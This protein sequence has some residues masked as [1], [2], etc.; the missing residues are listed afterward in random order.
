MFSAL[1][2]EALL[3]R[4]RLAPF[5]I[6]GS[7]LLMVVG[8]GFGVP[9]IVYAALDPVTQ[10]AD[11]AQL[12]GSL[13]PSA[14]HHAAAGSYPLFGGAIMLIL[15][16]LIT[17]SEYRWKTWHARLSQGP[18]RTAVVLAKATAGACAVIVIAAAALA[19][20]MLASVVI[21]SIEGKSL[22]LPGLSALAAALGATALISVAW[23]SVGLALGVIFRGVGTALAVGL[24]WTLG[25]ENAV[26]G[27]AGILPVLEPVRTILLGPASGSLVA[28]L[29]VPSLSEGGTPGVAAYVSGP[30]ACAVLIAYTIIG[31]AIATWLIRQRDIT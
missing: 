2:A 6:G 9:Y 3:L 5:V 18:T 31:V 20:A 25:L 15:G 27:L 24:V 22:A 7:W 13:L 10:A 14:A 23:M 16:V 17:G 8:F 26:A 28:A 11:R 21:A 4:K 12:L 1:T 29:G 30:A 19:A